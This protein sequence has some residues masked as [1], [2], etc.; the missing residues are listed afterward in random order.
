MGEAVPKQGEDNNKNKQ[1][2]V[3]VDMSKL[4]RCHEKVQ[5]E[6]RKMGKGEAGKGI[7]D[8]EVED[9]DDAMTIV[10]IRL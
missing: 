10:G 9:S 7:E 4:E 1:Y 6:G 2:M 8:R 5:R 3:V